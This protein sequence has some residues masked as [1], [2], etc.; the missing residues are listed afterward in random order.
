MEQKGNTTDR[1][2]LFLR[3]DHAHSPLPSATGTQGGLITGLW[4]TLKMRPGD[5]R[6]F[7]FSQPQTFLSLSL[8]LLPCLLHGSFSICFS[9]TVEVMGDFPPLNLGSFRRVSK[10]LRFATS[11]RRSAL[12]R[13]Q[14]WAHQHTEY[15]HVLRPTSGHLH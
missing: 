9:F 2:V 11:P 7:S 15:S 13:S 5:H 6:S 8:P 3:V 12:Y 10:H 14:S 4:L 1:F